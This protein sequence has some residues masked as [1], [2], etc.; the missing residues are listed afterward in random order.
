MLEKKK[1]QSKKDNFLEIVASKS[2]TSTLYSDKPTKFICKIGVTI[3][4]ASITNNSSLLISGYIN[5]LRIY[6]QFW[7]RIG[8]S[9]MKSGCT[10]VIRFHMKGCSAISYDQYEGKF[11]SRTRLEEVLS[12]TQIPIV[13]FL[14][15]K[16]SRLP[17]S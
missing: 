16:H 15:H 2:A 12:T 5:I 6:G 14:E 10:H 13:P 9:Y 3:S 1:L 11:W 8:T 17:L 4:P 7:S